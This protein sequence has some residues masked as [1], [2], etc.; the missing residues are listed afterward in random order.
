MKPE[1]LPELLTIAHSDF[2]LVIVIAF[3]FDFK[4]PSFF[5]LGSN[6][7]GIIMTLNDSNCTAPSCLAKWDFRPSNLTVTAW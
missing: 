4:N 7:L 1:L 2:N 3:S 5:N 6:N